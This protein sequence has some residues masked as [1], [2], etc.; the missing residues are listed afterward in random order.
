M[1]RPTVNPLSKILDII[2]KGK[3]TKDIEFRGD[4]YTFRSLNDEEY[5]WRDQFLPTSLPVMALFTAQ[6][7]PTL[8]IATVAIN[9]VLVEEIPEFKPTEQQAGAEVK[10]AAAYNLRKFYSDCPQWF[11]EGLYALYMDQVE[12]PARK[13][14]EGEV[15]NS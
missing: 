6:R 3:I 4:L 2:E 13:L 14:T 11:V 15:K 8:A 7:A 12:V 10:F 5:S 1:D 9:G